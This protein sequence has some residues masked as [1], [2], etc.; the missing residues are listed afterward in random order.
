[1]TFSNYLVNI[2][3]QLEILPDK[4]SIN[5]FKILILAFSPLFYRQAVGKTR[6]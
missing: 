3:T 4:V 5:L 1:M 6:N 2:L